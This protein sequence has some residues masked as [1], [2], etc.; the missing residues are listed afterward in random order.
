[1]AAHSQGTQGPTSRAKSLRLQRKAGQDSSQ[2]PP[3]FLVNPLCPTGPAPSSLGLS[4]SRGSP[5]AVE[6]RQTKG[7]CL[8]MGPLLAYSRIGICSGRGLLSFDLEPRV[9]HWWLH[10][11]PWLPGTTGISSIPQPLLFLP[12][13][14]GPR[15]LPIRPGLLQLCPEELDQTYPLGL[16]LKLNQVTIPA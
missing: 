5:A 10:Q 12:Q 13:P 2:C 8:L 9:P 16:E 1:M 11:L 7:Q 3:A 14:T 4:N 15:G 6:G